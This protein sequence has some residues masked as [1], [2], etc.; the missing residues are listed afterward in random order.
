MVSSKKW[1]YHG[2]FEMSEVWWLLI[3][4]S[5]V[6]KHTLIMGDIVN[7]KESPLDA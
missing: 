3:H 7:L 5:V 4:L 6:V 2:N 1:S